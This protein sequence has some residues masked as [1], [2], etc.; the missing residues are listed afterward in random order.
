MNKLL[1]KFMIIRFFSS[2][3][4]QILLFTIPLLVYK[5][6]HNIAMS[7]LAF[8]I[9]WLPRVL[10]LPF[11]GSL[12]DQFGG[13][14]IYLFADFIRAMMCILGFILI[15]LLPHFTFY[16]ASLLMGGCAFFYAQAFIAQESTIPTMVAS[17]DLHK[18]QS[19][20]QTLEQTTLVVGPFVASVLSYYLPIADLLLV[21]SIVFIMGFVG[22]SLLKN[23]SVTNQQKKIRQ[24]VL[25]DMCMG[26]HIIFHNK[27]LIWLSVLT[28]IVNLIWGLA[29]AT[30]AAMVTGY[31]SKTT[32][33]F[34][35]IQTLCGILSI[36]V[37]LLTPIIINRM[38][39]NFIGILSYGLIIA[40]GIA[41]SLSSHYWIF[42]IG[43]LLIISMDGVFNIYIRTERAKIIPKEH[44]GKTIGLIVLIN[45]LSIPLS[46]LLVANFSSN[47]GVKNLYLIVSLLA[48]LFL[49]LHLYQV[50]F[51]SRSSNM[52][53]VRN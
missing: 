4:D 53:V 15:N 30:D 44:L 29:L 35:F 27:K 50:Y 47:F 20:I 8:F 52:V 23:F 26:A 6:T 9:E 14:R 24:H 7:G 3:G 19:M 1:M 40:G 46:G 16:I 25:Q 48:G 36:T 2:L 43:Y 12:T 38:S 11:A 32:L 34:G 18:A 42:G 28:V 37:L 49:I 45:Q 22:M 5:A 33:D 13:R 41:I 17:T 39:I 21:T 51:K 31:F 10:S